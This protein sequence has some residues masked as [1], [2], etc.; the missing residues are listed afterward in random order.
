[1]KPSDP[2]RASR[3]I[4]L[5]TS[6]CPVGSILFLLF[7]FFFFLLPYLEPGPRYPFFARLVKR[8][9]WTLRLSELASK[10]P[11]KERSYMIVS[12]NVYNSE[13]NEILYVQARYSILIL[14]LSTRSLEHL[15]NTDPTS[16]NN[17]PHTFR[18]HLT[19]LPH[20]LL[21]KRFIRLPSSL[22]R[23]E[24]LNIHNPPS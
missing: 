21:P 6:T 24:T 13:L 1:M 3:C 17:L 20:T 5:A 10:T 14:L 2:S 23:C 9:G 16:R 11:R 15:L 7:L 19:P 18:L 4:S 12:D 22:Q 8:V